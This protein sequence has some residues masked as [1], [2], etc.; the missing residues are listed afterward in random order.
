MTDMQ[1]HGRI[2]TGHQLDSRGLS[3]FGQTLAGEKAW[4]LLYQ[5]AR[6]SGLSQEAIVSGQGPNIP[7]GSGHVVTLVI[8]SRSAATYTGAKLQF[9]AV[10]S[11]RFLS[12]SNKASDP[13]C[14]YLAPFSALAHE[15]APR[16]KARKTGEVQFF[17]KLL[18]VWGLD[19]QQ[20]GVLLG[21]PKV[22]Y[23]RDLLSGAA[24][25]RNRDAKDRLRNL[26]EIRTALDALYR[27]GTVEREWLREPQPDLEG[28]S[29]LDLLLEGSMENLLRVRQFVEYLSGR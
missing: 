1:N 18:D 10:S 27:D 23:V 8:A 6:G 16:L 15:P 5:G 3:M 9:A 14:I 4:D 7:V 24:S 21:F 2:P 22:E 17:E 28:M 26:I 13:D 11:E 20:G 12:W 19:E 29:P 25:L